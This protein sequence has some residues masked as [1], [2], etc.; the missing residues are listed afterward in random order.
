[1]RVADVTRSAYA[2]FTVRAI[3]PDGNGGSVAFGR[4]ANAPYP[5]VDIV[6]MPIDAG[7]TPHP[8]K[9]VVIAANALVS[10]FVG[11]AKTPTGYLVSFR[12][13]GNYGY[14]AA[15][16]DNLSPTAPPSR[17]GNEEPAPLA[18]SGAV[19]GGVVDHGLLLLDPKGSPLGQVNIPARTVTA[20]PGGF[21]VGGARYNFSSLAGHLTFVDREGKITASATIP[22]GWYGIGSPA[23]APHALGAAVFWTTENK[24]YGAVVSA[25]GVIVST[26]SL[27]SAGF[28]TS[29]IAV[30]ANAS[31][32]YGLVFSTAISNVTCTCYPSYAMYAMR[33]SDALEPLAP[34][35]T[36]LSTDSTSNTDPVVAAIGNEFVAAW[37]HV[38]DYSQNFGSR[39]L[40][41]PPAGSVNANASVP[42][43]LAPA[44]QTGLDI[45]AGADRTLALWTSPTTSTAIRLYATRFDRFGTRL[46][47]TPIAV[48]DSHLGAVATDGRDFMV[49]T[50][51]KLVSVDGHDGTV[52][53][54]VSVVPASPPAI[55]WDGTGYVLPTYD[56]TALVTRLAPDGTLLWSKPLSLPYPA[57]MAAI[58]GKTLIVSPQ[59]PAIQYQ[60]FDTAGNI[61]ATNAISA[62]PSPYLFDVASNGRDQF[63]LLLG[64]NSSSIYAARI[65]GDGTPIDPVAVAVGPPGSVH[66]AVASAAHWLLF[67]TNEVIDF[68]ALERH[69][70]LAAE[71]AVDASINGGG[72]ATLLTRRIEVIDGISV[73]VLSMREIVDPGA[74][75][76]RRRSVTR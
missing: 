47:A 61:V 57:A 26:A 38:L 50:G 18:C 52:R 40:R 39:I 74:P 71:W 20:L 68:P 13:L 24:V 67:L 6:A 12:D 53:N 22:D 7:G 65:G 41:I 73:S 30:A 43:G 21:A 49:N 60:I 72:R 9:S 29:E 45:A 35:A 8:E 10:S 69:S 55:V 36:L 76:P 14:V 48:A 27:P 19:C 37:Q 62:P 4:M 42:F 66:V 2:P 1:M 16:D 3:V 23:V 75:G 32:Q 33:V 34:P 63:L 5:R 54:V 28:Q 70:P 59:G 58:S 51:S 64:S 17:F 56:G 15:L 25:G 31:G 46:D 11:A 44:S